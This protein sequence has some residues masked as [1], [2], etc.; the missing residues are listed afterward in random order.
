MSVFGAGG[1]VYLRPCS[2]LP[3]VLH[4]TKRTRSVAFLHLVARSRVFGVFALRDHVPVRL[5]SK[6]KEMPCGSKNT[7]GD[8]FRKAPERAATPGYTHVTHLKSEIRLSEHLRT[9]A[10]RV[11]L[12]ASPR[13]DGPSEGT[14]GLIRF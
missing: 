1:V 2:R 11:T 6:R 4:A 3:C 9:R 7:A 13:H 5:T 10:R 8:R 12:R 14:D